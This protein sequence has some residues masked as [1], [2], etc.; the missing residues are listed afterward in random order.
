[1]R[2]RD[3][4]GS[5]AGA[6]LIYLVVSCASSAENAHS[7]A[8]DSGT[9]DALLD[10]FSVADVTD[11]PPNADADPAPKPTVD[12]VPCEGA[13]PWAE[14]LYPGRVK[15]DLAR[16][17]ALACPSAAPYCFQAAGYVKDGAFRILCGPGVTSATI[18][19]PPPP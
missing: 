5:L 9:L 19:M 7:S 17:V 8:R 11:G 15:E 2:W 18:T 16:G 1:M 12:T 4:T 6:V 3:V 13:G 14:K 10:S